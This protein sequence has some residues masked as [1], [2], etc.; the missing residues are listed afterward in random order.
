MFG[1]ELLPFSKFQG[2]GW[3]N[4]RRKTP[5]MHLR[6]V[7]SFVVE[8]PRRG[9][10]E[11][12]LK[13]ILQRGPMSEALW[14]R[15]RRVTV[16]ESPN[17]NTS[18]GHLLSAACA[19]ANASERKPPQRSGGGASAAE[20]AQR[21]RSPGM[22][23]PAVFSLGSLDSA[24]N[25]TCDRV[26]AALEEGLELAHTWTRHE[27]ASYCYG[28]LCVLLLTTLRSANGVFFWS[29]SQSRFSVTAIG[30]RAQASGT[31]PSGERSPR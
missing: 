24:L 22:Q 17:F 13:Q 15:F 12:G 21:S 29:A 11:Q 6:H 1:C 23:R 25:H 7:A 10:D 8:R 27:R 18:S 31:R 20:Q 30:E 9:N 2:K 26:T 3:F 14:L 4:D 19:E 16:R 5:A 28:A